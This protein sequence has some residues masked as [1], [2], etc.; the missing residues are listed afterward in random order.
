M[1]I[2]GLCASKLQNK[3][4]SI[5]GN[6][7]SDIDYMNSILSGFAKISSNNLKEYRDPNA[8]KHIPAY[9]TSFKIRGVFQSEKCSVAIT[10]T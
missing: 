8:T 4:F 5:S 3:K 7:H 10:A 2:A 9:K 6:S 1:P